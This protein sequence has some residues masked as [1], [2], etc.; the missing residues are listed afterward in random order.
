MKTAKTLPSYPQL[1]NSRSQRR[2]PFSS[3][4]PRLGDLRDYGLGKFDQVLNPLL[5]QHRLVQRP[6]A[7]LICAV[8]PQSP[9]D[10][11][12]IPGGQGNTGSNLVLPPRAACAQRATKRCYQSLT[13]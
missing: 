9:P 12:E 4:Y 2:W 1:R 3:R 5:C 8:V 11:M 13:N 6:H 10:P 7:T